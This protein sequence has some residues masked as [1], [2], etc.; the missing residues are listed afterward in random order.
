MLEAQCQE[1]D[2]AAWKFAMLAAYRTDQKRYD[3]AE[4]YLVRALQDEPSNMWWR[5]RRAD[6]LQKMGRTREAI[7]EAQLVLRQHP[8][9]PE[10][11]AIHAQLTGATP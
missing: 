3:V 7:E 4:K 6:V 11:R 10:A 1:P 8:T 9:A 5:I 2:A